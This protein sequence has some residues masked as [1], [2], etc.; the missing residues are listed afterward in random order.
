M[1]VVGGAGAEFRPVDIVADE[2][3]YYLVNPVEVAP[4]DNNEAKRSLRAGDELILSGEDLYDG[5]V[6]N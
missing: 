6:V 2:E 1:Y 5:K 4:G 3:D